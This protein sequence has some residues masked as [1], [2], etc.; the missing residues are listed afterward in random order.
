M[1]EFDFS[2]DF[3]GSIYYFYQNKS[4]VDVIFLLFQNE[5]YFVGTCI[6]FF[7][8]VFPITK[9]I[10]T[11]LSVY[12]SKWRHNKFISFIVQTLGKW[13]MA[14]VMVAACFLSF[15]SFANMNAGVDTESDVLHGMYFFLGFVLL[16]LLSSITLK[17]HDRRVKASQNWTLSH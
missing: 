8:I 9:L 12:S 16:S 2:R 14:D 4:V 1:G 13:S 11:I 3:E 10:F 15:L 5:N 6:L 17:I 7:S